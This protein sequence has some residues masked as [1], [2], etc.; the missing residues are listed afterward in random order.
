VDKPEQDEPQD[1]PTDPKKGNGSPPPSIVT[2]TFPALGTAD[3]TRV[4]RQNATSG[5]VV[6]AG[7]WLLATVLWEL[8]ATLNAQAAQRAQENAMMQS[9]MKGV[10]TKD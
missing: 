6:V 3:P 2:V 8:F 5:Q 9:L 10:K 4:D 1:V 7:F